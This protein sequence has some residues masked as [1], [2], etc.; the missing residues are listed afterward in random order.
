VTNGRIGDAHADSTSGFGEK[1]LDLVVDREAS[2]F[3]F[4][5]DYLAINDDVELTALTRFHLNLLTETGL[6]R[7]GQTGRAWL[8]ASNFAVENL[9]CHVFEA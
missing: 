5:K 8:V 6:E 3:T 7:R 1:I 2:N 4:G 9:G